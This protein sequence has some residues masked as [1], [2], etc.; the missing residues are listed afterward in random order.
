M[1]EELFKK[2]K[3]SEAETQARKYE[4]EHAEKLSGELKG[5]REEI[6][7]RIPNAQSSSEEGQHPIQPF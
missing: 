1:F 2:G 6:K 3:G 4:K 7:K 5:L